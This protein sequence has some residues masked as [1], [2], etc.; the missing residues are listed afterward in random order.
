MAGDEQDDGWR[1]RRHRSTNASSASV[2]T[3]VRNHSV[4]ITT[5]ATQSATVAPHGG[6]DRRARLERGSLTGER[7]AG[8]GGSAR[9]EK[10]PCATFHGD[11][12]H[13]NDAVR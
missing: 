10:K 12:I 4:N 1:S 13:S 2:R 8:F 11:F 9:A 3:P 7:H 5:I 6:E